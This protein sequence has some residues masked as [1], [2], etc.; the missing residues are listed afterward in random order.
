MGISEL[1][2]FISRFIKLHCASSGVFLYS[3]FY[4]SCSRHTLQAIWFQTLFT[5]AFRSF[6]RSLCQRHKKWFSTGI[7]FAL[8]SGL[9]RKTTQ[10]EKRI[11]QKQAASLKKIENK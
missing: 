8:L 9:Y 11:I 10:K 4:G 2:P 5:G 1:K 3:F 6:L 7:G